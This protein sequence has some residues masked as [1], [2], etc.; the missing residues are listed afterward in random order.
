MK[1]QISIKKTGFGLALIACLV[2][3]GRAMA[4][5]FSYDSIGDAISFTGGSKFTFLQTDG[6]YN[7]YQAIGTFPS[8][9][10]LM[11]DITGTF[12]IGAVT[13]NGTTSNAP[14]TGTGTFSMFDGATTLTAT[15]SW[16]D[17][18]QNGTG[19]TLDYLGAA[20]LT[21][22]AYTGTNAEL[23]ALK[24]AGSGSDT[25][26]FTFNPAKTLSQL[27]SGEPPTTF[28]GTVTDV[29]GVPD[30]GTTAL[31]ISLGLAGTAIVAI[32]RRRRLLSV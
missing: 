28:S 30:S 25:L 13:V 20:N 18:V 19:T 14:I 8:L 31:L 23:L 9:T 24:H 27:K 11:G 29:V 26:D 7:I 4:N 22:I 15:L 1:H 17:I 16:V 21:S 2:G 6:S 32:A 10:Y 12:T 3:G 5:G